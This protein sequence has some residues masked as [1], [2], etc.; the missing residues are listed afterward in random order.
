MDQLLGLQPVSHGFTRHLPRA[1]LRR[2]PAASLPE[3]H[4]H[5]SS[6]ETT[7]WLATSA[8]HHLLVDG[9][10]PSTD[11]VSENRTHHTSAVSLLRLRSIFSI[12][13]SVTHGSSPWVAL[14]SGMTFP[15]P[16][17]EI[18]G[19]F[20][21]LRGRHWHEETTIRPR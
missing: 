19:S 15:I 6:A 7:E 8:R 2:W 1:F 13:A 4:P 21:L 10:R 12:S 16:S 5:S 9:S 17:V 11:L 20:L 14:Y 18:D 3:P